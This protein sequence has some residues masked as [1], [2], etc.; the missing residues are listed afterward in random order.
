MTTADALLV[1]LEFYPL[2]TLKE[3]SRQEIERSLASIMDDVKAR[4]Q[5]EP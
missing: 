2:G 4:A 3:L 5:A 1:W